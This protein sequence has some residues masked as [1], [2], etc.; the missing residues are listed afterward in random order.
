[1]DEEGTAG[2]ELTM[3]EHKKVTTVETETCLKVAKSKKSAVLDDFCEYMRYCRRGTLLPT[4]NRTPVD[5]FV[6]MMRHGDFSSGLFLLPSEDFWQQGSEHVASKRRAIPGA[7]QATYP[8]M[9][10]PSAGRPQ[11]LLNGPGEP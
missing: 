6:S 5:I 1:L 3:Q 4:E 9:H 10:R 11:G 7:L 2:T 8:D